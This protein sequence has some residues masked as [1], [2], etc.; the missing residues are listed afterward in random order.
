MRVIEHCGIVDDHNVAKIRQP[1]G[2]R[3][4]LVGVFL[5][6]GDEQ[7]GAAVA[8]LIFDFRRRSGRIDAIDDRT[9][10]LRG[11]V[12]D[13]PFLV[14]LAHNREPLARPQTEIGKR[15][16]HARVIAPGPFAID[17]EMFGAKCE[18]VGAV[19]RQ[20]AKQRPRRPDA[21]VVRRER[22]CSGMSDF[23]YRPNKYKAR[24]EVST[25]EEK[26]ATWQ[27]KCLPVQR[28]VF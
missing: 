4:Q 18:T 26:Q 11:E 27:R 9:E 19:S 17:A 13:D 16:C 7:G 28:S 3:Q 21:Q 25:A 2:Q 12:A 14:G 1:V 20:L 10:R 8:H 5:I 22:D 23:I 15:P 6:L 24:R